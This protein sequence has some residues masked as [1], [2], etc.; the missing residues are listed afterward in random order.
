LTDLKLAIKGHPGHLT[1][2]ICYAEDMPTVSVRFVFVLC[3]TIEDCSI[4]TYCCS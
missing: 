3:R 4:V 2:W 1:N